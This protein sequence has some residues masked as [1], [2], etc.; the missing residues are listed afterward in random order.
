MILDTSFV[1]DLAESTDA[2]VTTERELEAAG[3]SLKIPSMVVLELYI[4]VET[5]TDSEHERQQVGAILD[6]YPLIDMTPRIARR[7]GRLLGERVADADE[8]AGPGIGKGDAA[9]AATAIERDEPVLTA[10]DHFETIPGVRVEQ[11][12]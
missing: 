5:V 2:A 1:L 6:S 3:V 12:R 11:Y 9:I 4:G 8:G 7:A 10:D